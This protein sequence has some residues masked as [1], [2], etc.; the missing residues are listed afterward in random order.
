MFH[1]IDQFPFDECFS[2]IKWI[3]YFII[4]DDA[5]AIHPFSLYRFSPFSKLTMTAKEKMVK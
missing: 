2:I 5:I 3:P 1:L 4:I